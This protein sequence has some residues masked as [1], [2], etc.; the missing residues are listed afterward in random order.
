DALRIFMLVF[1]KA[2]FVSR[3]SDSR[4]FHRRA[5]EEGCFYEQRVA[6]SLSSLVFE[7]VFPE[8][9]RAIAK[10]E[11]DAPLDDVRNAAL[12]LLYRLLFLLYAE[13]R[14]LLPVRES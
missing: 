2:S 12:V 11:P 4:T 13:D 14:D 6:E 8:L 10:S 3:P 7:Q 5:V 9:V 1:G